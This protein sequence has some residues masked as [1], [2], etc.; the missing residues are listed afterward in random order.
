MAFRAAAY[1]DLEAVFDAGEAKTPRTFPAKLT[2][3]DG[4]RV[5]AGRDFTAGGE[6]R[7]S[8]GVVHLDEQR[9]HALAA[10]LRESPFAVRSVESKPYRRSPYAPFRTTTLQQ[11][12][13]RK[14]GY[15]AARTMQV[16]QRLYEN[17]FI[18]YMRTDSITLSTTAIAA[19]RRQV[20]ELFGGEYLPPV[21][22]TYTSKV[23][24]AQEAHEAIRPA[25]EQFRTPGQTGLTG[26]EFRLYE[27]IWMRTVASQ[28][29][30]AEGRSVSVRIAASA[31]T[32]EECE[33]SASGR[34]ITF[35]G[36]LKAYVEG[37]DD[38]ETERDDRET[39]LPDVAEGDPLS[40]AELQPA[41]HET[42]PPARYT[43][44]TLIR[45]LEEREIGRPS[46]YASIMGTILNRGYVYKKGSALVPAWLAFS[47][48][49]LLERH[50][51]R[52]VDYNFTAGME[53]VLDDVA[54]GRRNST[55]ELA[56]FY[57][58]SGD[59]QGLKK[60]VSELGE[61]D[62][63]E[64]STFK[65][66]DGIALRVGKYGPYVETADEQ[67]ANVPEDL[68]PDELTVEKAKELLANPSG[69]ERLLGTDPDTG[70]TV[71]AKS[72]RYGP[73]VTEVLDDDASNGKPRT[74]SLFSSMTVDSVTLDEALRL[75]TL[76]RVLGTDP[77]TS[78]VIEAANGRYG[79]YI[80][81]DKEYRS[82]ESEDQLFTVSLPEAVEL[83]RQPKT[84]G[85]RAAAAP[86]RELGSDPSTTRQIVIKNGRFGPY[87]TDGE[88][89]ATLRR[90]DDVETVSL[91]R[92]A[93]LLAERRAKGPAPARP[94]P[95][96]SATKKPAKRTAKKAAVKKSTAKKT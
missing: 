85:R 58:G 24:N 22:R 15:G 43:E 17:G 71:V 18:T 56:E 40:V 87:V 23:K 14:L 11:E 33:F 2:A 36:F 55:D 86:L 73:Y 50:F 57:F 96:K 92:A 49:R 31:T 93:E 4:S 76:P 21:P 5:A 41:G 52:L 91:D 81:R 7:S 66:G 70:R 74:S 53:D 68:P 69:A 79:P 29:K 35:H 12:A 30:D 95:R 78:E 16:A 63:R 26:D 19:A 34:V 45:E 59:L 9:A 80:R 47:V 38:P 10:A 60:M 48:V 75:L 65:I 32:G 28:M 88:V 27:L 3:V 13:S 82:L 54:A 51:T 37:A 83:L 77:E 8:S 64:L 62:A 25:G 94:A 72:G 84:R 89:N 6:L 20:S 46:T 42:R 90:G 67:R 39:R 44:A 61:I 1:W